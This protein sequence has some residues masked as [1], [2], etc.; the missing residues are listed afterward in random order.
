MV[1]TIKIAFK[2]SRLDF[3]TIV[4]RGDFELKLSN[5]KLEIW[6]RANFDILAKSL[7]DIR[8]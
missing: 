5:I 4:T 2:S 1:I 7:S 6:L 3:N 8:L